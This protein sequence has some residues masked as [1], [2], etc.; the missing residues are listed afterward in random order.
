MAGVWEWIDQHW[1]MISG[2]AATAAAWF[3]RQRIGSLW[4]RFDRLTS[5]EKTIGSLRN[6]LAICQANRDYAV[7]ALQEIT[8][9]AALLNRARLNGLLTT[10]SDSPTAPLGSPATSPRSPSTPEPTTRAGTSGETG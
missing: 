7:M 4:A 5:P 3:G 9:S 10:S 8:E 6:D 1:P 2:L